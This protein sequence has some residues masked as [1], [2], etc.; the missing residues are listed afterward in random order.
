MRLEIKFS[1]RDISSD[2]VE[3]WFSRLR[4]HQGLNTSF[5]VL[6]FHQLYVRMQLMTNG[7]ERFCKGS[8]E[9]DSVFDLDLSLAELYE[10]KTPSYEQ[11]VALAGDIKDKCPQIPSI[12]FLRLTSLHGLA[13]ATI[14]RLVRVGGWLLHRSLTSGEF[15]DLC[16]LVETFIVKKQ[17]ILIV[18]SYGFLLWLAKVDQSTKQSMDALKLLTVFK[19][20]FFYFQTMIMSNN[21]IF[22]NDFAQLCRSIRLEQNIETANAWKAHGIERLAKFYLRL[23]SKSHLKDTI[24]SEDLQKRKGGA[25]SFRGDIGKEDSANKKPALIPAP[26]ATVNGRRVRLKYETQVEKA[27][28]SFEQ[29]ENF[30]LPS[31]LFSKDY[32]SG[33]AALTGAKH[34]HPM[35]F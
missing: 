1:L 27:E 11:F 8:Y 30:I 14:K 13:E 5:T 19:S 18:P 33:L 24:E 23:L 31:D 7:G 17:G 29:P 20:G 2:P 9:H 12:K 26:E 22:L 4:G 32:F 25:Q 16:P 15:K 28:M 21:P 10:R 34:Y 35:Q 6:N 3:N